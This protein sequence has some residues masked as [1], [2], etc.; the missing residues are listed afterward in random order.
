M[1][2]NSNQDAHIRA[3]M[4]R[5]EGSLKR[6]RMLLMNYAKVIKSYGKN[7][8]FTCRQQLYIE[9]SEPFANLHW[10]TAGKIIRSY[11]KSHNNKDIELMISNAEALDYLDIIIELKNR[12][13]K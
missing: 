5:R 2:S 8:A 11:L 7:A 10:K 3:S 6:N 13:I 12:L 4:S 9:A 1:D